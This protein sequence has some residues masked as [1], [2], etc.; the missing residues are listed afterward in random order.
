MKLSIRLFEPL[1]VNTFNLV[2]Q[3]QCV[4]G[5]N[6]DQTLSDVNLDADPIQML[7]RT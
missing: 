2:V 3:I 4:M 1:K 5:M 6:N 7:N